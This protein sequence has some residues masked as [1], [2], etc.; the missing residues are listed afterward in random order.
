MFLD[1]SIKIFKKKNEEK[2]KIYASGSNVVERVA[3]YRAVRDLRLK[4]IHGRRNGRKKDKRRDEKLVSQFSALC[5]ARNAPA[6]SIQCRLKSRL[7][8]ATRNR[9]FV[10]LHF[11]EIVIPRESQFGSSSA[12][13]RYSRL[14]NTSRCVPLRNI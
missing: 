6:T 8:R 5:D 2:T 9:T 11:E 12:A 7:V 13:A 10:P 1:Q 14:L 4:K 3:L